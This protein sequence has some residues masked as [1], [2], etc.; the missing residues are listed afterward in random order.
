MMLTV[1]ET[2]KRYMRSSRKFRKAI[3]RD[4]NVA[5]E[6]LVRAGIAIRDKSS[7]SGIVLAKEFR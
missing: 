4:P 5:K 3:K 6:A 1:A 2:V 7:K